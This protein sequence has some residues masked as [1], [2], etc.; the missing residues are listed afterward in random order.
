MARTFLSAFLAE[1]VLACWL[2]AAV[3]LSLEADYWMPYNGDGGIE[4]GYV[5]DLAKAIFE[6]RGI[7][8]VFSMTPWIR[9]IE[10]ARFGKCMAIVGALKEDVPDF[11][12]P[13]EE[14][15]RGCFVFYV[16]AGTAWKYAGIASL[17]GRTLGVIKDYA[18][19]PALNELIK[20]KPRG[21]H[22]SFGTR[23]LENNLRLL[24]LDRLD[25]VI[26]D[27]NVMKYFVGKKGLEG[28]VVPAGDGSELQKNYIAFSPVH[29]NAKEYAAILTE[30]IQALR[31]SGQLR[32][33]LAKYGL[34]D[35]K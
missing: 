12:F 7:P 30:G 35:W 11:I 6:P 21:I 28:Q 3:P 19:F 31:K 27:C 10:D 1:L 9:A 23:P 14:T 33:I 2:P 22:V 32:K 13:G 8:V 25:V 20:T 4:T 15:G 18:Y 17:E 34:S 16:K 5:L 29:P 24:L 26:D